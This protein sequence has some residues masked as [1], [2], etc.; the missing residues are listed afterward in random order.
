VW[1]RRAVR[2]WAASTASC[3]G[4]L[5]V[6]TMSLKFV[7]GPDGSDTLMDVLPTCGGLFAVIAAIVYVPVF[8]VLSATL[9]QA[10]SRTIAV[11]VGAGLSPIA[12]AGEAWFFADR[13]N[14]ETI[15]VAMLRWALNMN[16]SDFLLFTWPFAL[17]GV[18]FGLVWSAQGRS[19][20]PS[21]DI[22]PA[23]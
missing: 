10:F 4:F 22:G 23:I 7:F 12:Y 15:W 11:L 5:A 9:R 6:W 13:E 14:A 3:L 2:T 19:V 1:L 20:A 18:V 16:K 17:A 8:V 21:Q